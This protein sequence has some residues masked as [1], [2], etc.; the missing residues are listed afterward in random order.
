MEDYIVVSQVNK[1]IKGQV[2]VQDVS[3]QIPQGSIVGLCG[4]N[5]A[6]KSTIL[7]LIAGILQPTSGEITVNRRHWKTDREIFAAQMGYMPD[8]FQFPQGMTAKEMLSFWAALRKVPEGRVQEVLELVG[9]ADKQTKRVST[10]SKG[11]KQ[12]VL[13]VQSILAEPPLLLMDEP[14]NGLD[15]YWIKEFVKLIR[16]VKQEGQTVLFS[17]HQLD[18]AEELADYVIFLQDGQLCGEGSVDSCRELFGAYPLQHAFQFSMEM[19]R[20]GEEKDAE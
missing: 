20:Q 5:G 11:M 17:T 15:P 18:V 16:Q 1:T 14:T 3:F 10:F 19:A 13:F 2:I 12:R 6:G 7:R 9:L 8:D 4:G